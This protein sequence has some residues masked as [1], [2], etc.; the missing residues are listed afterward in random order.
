MNC[1]TLKSKEPMA[2]AHKMES[3]FKK[4]PPDCSLF[5]KENFQI[6]IHKELLYQTQFMRDMV[7]SVS[8]DSKIE[9]ICHL[10]SIVYDLLCI[11]YCF[12]YVLVDLV[13][14][15]LCVMF[16]YHVLFVMYS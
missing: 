11:T 15:V 4:T 1:T 9:V 10:L 2:L 6:P 7:K 5:S 16:R 13:Y 8:P 3:Y 14:Y 12:D